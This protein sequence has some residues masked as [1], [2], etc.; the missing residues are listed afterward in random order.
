MTTNENS[1]ETVDPTVEIENEQIEVVEPTRRQKIIAALKV[2]AI[3]GGAA[4]IAASAAAATA[5]AA[6]SA[7]DHF[8]PSNELDA[9]D[10]MLQIEG[11]VVDL[12]LE[13]ED[14]CIETIEA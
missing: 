4:A 12:P 8:S 2:T 14:V 9:Y 13:I 1:N 7:I 3:V 10:C 5:V 6:Q 11:D